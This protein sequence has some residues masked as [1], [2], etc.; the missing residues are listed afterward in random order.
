M[1][2]DIARDLRVPKIVQHR[3]RKDE[4]VSKA[5]IAKANQ[6]SLAIQGKAVRPSFIEQSSWSSKACA[7]KPVPI[8]D[9]PAPVSNWSNP[10]A[11]A[12]ARMSKLLSPKR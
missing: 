4:P 8:D 3:K 5:F 9:R 1:R 10:N 11:R 6:L 2:K 7:T 12:N